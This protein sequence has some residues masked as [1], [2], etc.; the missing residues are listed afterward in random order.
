[1]RRNLLQQRRNDSAAGTLTYHR[2]NLVRIE[3]SI[4]LLMRGLPW[5]RS[6][7]EEGN[8]IVQYKRKRHG[9][10]GRECALRGFSGLLDKNGN[11]QTL[12]DIGLL[13][14]V[15][16]NPELV[17]RAPPEGTSVPSSDEAKLGVVSP[18]AVA[19]I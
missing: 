19:L 18:V 11:Q 7:N 14:T 5:R 1:M 15:G 12:L 17:R 10:S 9:R 8:R 13:L 4:L 16:A 3:T 2:R 6:R